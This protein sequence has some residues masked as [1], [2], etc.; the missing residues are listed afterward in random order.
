MDTAPSQC[1]GKIFSS[2]HVYFERVGFLGGDSFFLGQAHFAMNSFSYDM[3]SCHS[4]QGLMGMRIKML[5][6]LKCNNCLVS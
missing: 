2:L 5:R 6:F 1:F 3:Y 4:N